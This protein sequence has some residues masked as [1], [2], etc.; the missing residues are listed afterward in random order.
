M[1]EV[2]VDGARERGHEA[3]AELENTEVNFNPHAEIQECH[4]PVGGKLSHVRAGCGE[5]QAFAFNGEVLFK[6]MRH[7]PRVGDEQPLQLRIHLFEYAPIIAVTRGELQG[8]NS[9]IKVTG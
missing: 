5:E 9:T 8:E 7:I 1:R 4:L 6:L 2:A 3:I